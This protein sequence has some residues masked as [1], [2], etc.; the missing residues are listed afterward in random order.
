MEEEDP[1]KHGEAKWARPPR[2]V[3]DPGT[4]GV[5]V[6]DASCLFAK[7]ARYLLLGFAVHGI[8]QA[9]WSRRLLEETAG[10]LARKLR[11][12]SLE[13][14][15]RWLKNEAD[16]VR[17][18]LVDG[19]E[20]WIEQINLPDADDAHVVAAA[21]ESGATTI[22]TSNL[23]DF[24]DEELSRFSI[25]ATDPDE[26]ALGCINANP[27]LA[28]RIASDHPA[29]DVFLDR[30]EASLPRTAELLKALLG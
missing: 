16:L 4:M 13:D 11:G 9:R 7:H 24:P 1:P 22:V 12:D 15:G 3:P 29:P 23:R 10:S 5:A 17:D 19:Y 6:F 26:F 30:L 28:T 18:G 8:V 27:V 21:I 2:S 14:L 25:T 20:G